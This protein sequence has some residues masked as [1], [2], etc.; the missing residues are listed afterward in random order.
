MLGGN[1]ELRDGGQVVAVSKL[2]KALEPASYQARVEQSADGA[3]DLPEFFDVLW[4][5]ADACQPQRDL[6]TATP[7]WWRIALTACDGSVLVRLRHGSKISRVGS[8]Y[9]VK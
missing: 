6:R 7:R 5:A 1:Q 4:D 2:A 8:G 9:E 3:G